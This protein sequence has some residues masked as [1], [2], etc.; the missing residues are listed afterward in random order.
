M[1]G[2][3]KQRSTAAFLGSQLLCCQ[4]PA[5]VLAYCRGPPTTGAPAPAIHPFVTQEFDTFTSMHTPKV[6][7]TAH[8]CTA[9]TSNEA[10]S[11]HGGD[12]SGHA[13]AQ[14]G[15]PA[16]ESTAPRH[17]GRCGWGGRGCSRPSSPHCSP[18]LPG[19]LRRTPQRLQPAGRGGVGGLG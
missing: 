15:T 12:P 19:G 2:H 4:Q 14:W 8:N 5:P 17:C 10:H 18:A 7:H 16:T 13:G 1:L 11:M 3:V 9:P 6:Q